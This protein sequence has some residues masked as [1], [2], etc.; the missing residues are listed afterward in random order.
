[1]REEYNPAENT[2]GDLPDIWRQ[3]AEFLK[4]YGDPSTGRLWQLAAVELDRALRVLGEETLTLVEAAALCGYSSD[5][6][7]SLVCKGKLPNYGRKNAPRILR[8]DLPA[9]TSASPGRPQRNAAGDIVD[10]RSI[11]NKTHSRR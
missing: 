6:L 10:V 5:H 8:S 1:M 9:K 11:I 3:R 2:P 7:G 4:E